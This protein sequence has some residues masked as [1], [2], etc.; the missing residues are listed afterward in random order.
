[1]NKS[2]QVK[3]QISSHYKEN[4]INYSDLIKHLMNNKIDS[5]KMTLVHSGYDKP[6]ND[7]YP[8]IF[9][10]D[11]DSILIVSGGLISSKKD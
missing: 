7:D 1:M 6:Y 9:Y 2:K 4:Y 11:D 3:E 8:A 10:Y 5:S